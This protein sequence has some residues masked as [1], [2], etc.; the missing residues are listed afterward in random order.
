MTIEEILSSFLCSSNEKGSLPKRD[1]QDSC[2]NVNFKGKKCFIFQYIVFAFF[3]LQRM[4]T[5]FKIQSVAISF[6]KK[7]TAFL[8]FFF[9][10]F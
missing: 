8:L 6:L 4:F 1:I 9:L 7:F 3:P 2:L 10:S 5:H